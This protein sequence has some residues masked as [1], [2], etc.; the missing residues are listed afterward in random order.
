LIL[1]RADVQRA[2]KA[3]IEGISTAKAAEILNNYGFIDARIRS[4][5]G[6]AFLRRAI[7]LDPK[8]TVA[9]LNL[10][11][12]LRLRLGETLDW[13]EKQRISAEA[14]NLYT[15]YLA[16]G[17]HRNSTI[18]MFLRGDLGQD[19]PDDVCR[20]IS[21]YAKAGRLAELLSSNPR[22][23]MVGQRLV[24]LIFTTEGTDHVPALE[25]YDAD[26]DERL[27]YDAI[28]LPDAPGLAGDDR[29]ALLAYRNT[30]QI[31]HLSDTMQPVSTMTL[32]GEVGC[33]FD[34]V[35]TKH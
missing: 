22:R 3:P 28:P 8:R 34:S 33:R 23:V 9:Y 10:A 6:E 1:E 26:T 13:M 31:I 2:L 5:E 25:A 24:N 16:L 21:S 7:E 29:L 12:L 17:G 18:D 30:R 27:D 11:D 20:V 35:M 15:D 14:K 4:L 19:Y 32:S